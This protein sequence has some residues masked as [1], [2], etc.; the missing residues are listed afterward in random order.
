MRLSGSAFLPWPRTPEFGRCDALPILNLIQ[1]NAP[2]KEI[3]KARERKIM[4]AP[5]TRFI[6]LRAKFEAEIQ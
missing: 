4:E 3:L 1:Q 2:R 5:D 6:N